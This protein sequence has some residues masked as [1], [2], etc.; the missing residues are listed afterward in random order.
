MTHGDVG[1]LS[2]RDKDYQL[3]RITS[4]F[5]DEACPSLKGKPRLFFIQACRGQMKDLGHYTKNIN[6]SRYKLKRHVNDLDYN[7]DTATPF[8]K[9]EEEEEGDEDHV[10]NPPNHPDFLIVRSAYSGHF[11]LRNTGTGS[12]FIQD[13][14]KELEQNGTRHDILNLLTHANWSVSERLG[15]G[16]NLKQILCISNMLTKIL[17]FNIKKN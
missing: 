2:S 14:C 3:K 11:S 5:T 15:I 9:E 12:W 16:N 17:I 4:Y 7:V 10:H 8:N 13:L 6:N 1:K